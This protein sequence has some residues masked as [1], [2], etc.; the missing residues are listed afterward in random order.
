MIGSDDC[1][2]MC[3]IAIDDPNKFIAP[4]PRAAP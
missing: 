2:R 3:A 4:A 1:V